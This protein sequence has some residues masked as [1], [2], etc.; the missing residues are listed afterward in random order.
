METTTADQPQLQ[1]P[2]PKSSDYLFGTSDSNNQD[3]SFIWDTTLLPRVQNKHA[4]LV[5]V[6]PKIAEVSAVSHAFCNAVEVFLNE[7]GE[8]AQLCRDTV[9]IVAET[10]AGDIAKVMHTLYTDGVKLLDG[11]TRKVTRY[12]RITRDTIGGIEVAL[13]CNI[14]PVACFRIDAKFHF[15]RGNTYEEQAEYLGDSKVD[16]EDL[17]CATVVGYDNENQRVILVGHKGYSFGINS[18]FAVS[19]YYLIANAVD[20]FVVREM[21]GIRACIPEELYNRNPPQP[22]PV[23]LESEMVEAEKP[24]I[25]SR[26]RGMFS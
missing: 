12:E 7:I 25:W 21:D 3:T 22:K 10:H 19:A 23:P 26:L 18:F 2:S 6:E 5:A 15:L 13:F 24:S 8:A 17:Y 4:L 9:A 14:L 16:S 11:R 20:V 1:P